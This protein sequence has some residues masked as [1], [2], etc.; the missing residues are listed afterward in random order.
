MLRWNVKNFYFRFSLIFFIIF[1]LVILWKLLYNKYIWKY[2]QLLNIKSYLFVSS[3]FYVLIYIEK[4]S[5]MLCQYTLYK[6]T[7][8]SKF[9][10]CIIIMNENIQ[11]F[12]PSHR[13]FRNV[14]LYLLKRHKGIC[15]SNLKNLHKKLIT[16]S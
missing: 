14:L 10:K 1:N 11:Q 12:L 3:F 9:T 4:K 2:Q 5:Q 7:N 16:S 13:R 6:M 15:F 8:V